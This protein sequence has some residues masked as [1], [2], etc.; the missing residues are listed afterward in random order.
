MGMGGVE[1]RGPVED[2][3]L[4]AVNG[5]GGTFDALGIDC[6]VTVA[7]SVEPV[8]GGWVNPVNGNG[9]SA[10]SPGALNMNDGCWLADEATPIVPM[11]LEAVF[12]G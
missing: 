5:F 11:V 2:D 3:V 9:F 12:P 10:T 6:D 4:A 7:A 8:K 1:N